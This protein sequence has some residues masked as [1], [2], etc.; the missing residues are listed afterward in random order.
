MDRVFRMFKQTRFMQ[1]VPEETQDA[2][3]HLMF[4]MAR[5]HSMPSFAMLNAITNMIDEEEEELQ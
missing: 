5:D 4:Q 1:A 2:I 3:G